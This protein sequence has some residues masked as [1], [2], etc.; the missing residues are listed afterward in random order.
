MN[1]LSNISDAICDNIGVLS[2]RNKNKNI[3]GNQD[4]YAYMLYMQIV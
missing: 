2:F 1:R 3:Y 4:T